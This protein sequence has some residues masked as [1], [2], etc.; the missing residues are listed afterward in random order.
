MV[1]QTQLS[2]CWWSIPLYDP[3]YPNIPKHPM[4]KIGYPNNWIK[5]VVS[6]VLK[7]L[8]HS[9]THIPITRPG[10]REQKANWKIT[11]LSSVKHLFIWSI[12]HSYVKLPEGI[13]QSRFDAIWRRAFS[14]GKFLSSRTR[15]RLTT[16]FAA[17]S[18]HGNGNLRY[19]YPPFS[20]KP[21]CACIYIYIR[22]YIY[23]ERE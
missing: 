6:Q 7:K 5:S 8:I 9:D 3:C 2:Y 23:I 21:I 13:F 19:Q 14:C 16:F 22:I 4:V 10:K 17:N 15:Q 20:D 1:R 18:P 12:F 11:I